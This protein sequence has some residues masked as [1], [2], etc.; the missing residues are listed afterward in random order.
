[1]SVQMTIEQ[2]NT[3]STNGARIAIILAIIFFGLY[4]A[5]VLM[6]K[7]TIVYGWKIFHFGNVGEFLIM[8]AASIAFIV[9]AI[10]RE[11]ALKSNPKSDQN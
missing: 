1:M 11:S 10:T 7:A 8:L 4:I 6:G 5:N 9:A 3:D 2:Q